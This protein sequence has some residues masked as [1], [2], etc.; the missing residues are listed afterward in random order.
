MRK[1]QAERRPRGAVQDGADP[2]SVRAG[3]PAADGGGGLPQYCISLV[4]EVQP[5]GGNTTFLRGELQFPAPVYRRD[6]RLGIPL[7]SGGSGA[8]GISLPQG[9]FYRRHAHQGQCQREK[10]GE[11]T[12]AHGI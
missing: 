9:S 6:S 4:S 10:V 11:G 7:D 12:D 5:A 1:W 3:V 8:G 2:A